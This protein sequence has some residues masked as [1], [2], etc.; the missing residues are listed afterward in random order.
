MNAP[1]RL[2]ATPV[3]LECGAPYGAREK[4]GEFCCPAHRMAWN[5]RRLQRGAELYD[6]FMALRFERPLAAKLNLWTIVCRAA[7]FF[8]T[9]DFAARDG[10]RSWG[11]PE[12]VIDRRPYLTAI[13]MQTARRRAA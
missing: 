1:T 8:R 7:T 11:A 5:N 2:N 13:V 9:E 10:R 12:R 3:C 4:G 6:L